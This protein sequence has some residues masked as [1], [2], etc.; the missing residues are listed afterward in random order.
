MLNSLFSNVFA[1]LLNRTKNG[2]SS[3]GD[4]RPPTGIRFAA[5]LFATKRADYYRFLADMFEGTKGRISLRE[6]FLNDVSRYGSSTRGKLS[7][8]WARR[9]DDGGSLF[10]T[11]EGTLP[12]QDVAVLDAL[13]RNSGEG[14][15]EE[16]LRDLATN[17]ELINSAR[18]TFLSSM[19]ASLFCLALVMALIF[20]MPAYTVPKIQAA[21][22]MLPEEYFPSSG[23]QLFGFADYVS[24]NWL[25]ITLMAS[26]FLGLC[27]WSLSNLTGPV[28]LF[29]DRYFI[30]WGMHR[31]FE[32]VRFLAN[33]AA[34]LRKHGNRSRGLR[35]AIVIQLSE[36]SRW[37]AHH[38]N[39]MLEIIDGGDT[40]SHVFQTG[41][42]DRETSW[43][44]SDLISSCGLEDALQ[45]VKERLKERV[46]GGI[47]RKAT[48][49]SWTLMLAAI[50][51]AA[52]LMLWH[53]TVIDDMRGALQQ[54]ISS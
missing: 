11:F 43:Y 38:I 15:L 21:F 27:F 54:Y 1:D 39:K 22:S 7:L 6:V 28:R 42:L 46:L 52:Y 33:L 49:L 10:R 5:L 4:E 30:V 31:D 14:A 24:G 20:T 25:K 51:V 32:S 36:A 23:V 18:A 34:M 40:G 3:V 12:R 48:V 2:T 37:R 29:F 47:Q 50:M 9:F 44:L 19:A 35:E 8:Y 13:Q 16:G 26:A 41:M 45:Y 17:T 53:I